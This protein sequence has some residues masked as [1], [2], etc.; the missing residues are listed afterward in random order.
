MRAHFDVIVIGGGPAGSTTATL[1]AKQGYRVLLLEKTKFPRYHIGE[2]M[3]TGILPLLGELGL[4]DEISRH[5]FIKKYGGTMVWGKDYEHWD[6]RFNE[7]DCFE[8]AY[9]VVRAEFDHLLLQNARR[10]G[11]TVLEETRVVETLFEKA[12]CIG[13][14]YVSAHS[15]TKDAAYASFIVDASGQTALL[16]RKMKYLEWRDDL[17]NIAIWAYYQGGQT[18]EGKKAGDI[19]VE[20]VSKGWLWVIPLHDNTQSVGWVVPASE[21]NGRKNL[22]EVY[23]QMIAHS[24]V[25]KQLLASAT[26]VSPFSTA[27]DWSYISKRFAG[28]GFLLVGDAAGFVDPLFSTGVFLAMKSASLA[29]KTIQYALQGDGQESALLAQYERLYRGSLDTIFSFICFFYDANKEKEIYWKEAQQLIDPYQE[30]LPRENF[31]QLV[32]GHKIGEQ[33]I[34][35]PLQMLAHLD[36]ATKYAN[37]LL[38]AQSLGIPTSPNQTILDKQARQE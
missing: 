25:A 17:K 18:Q 4:T 33:R 7:E 28:P 6:F 23:D 8:H 2:S 36:P 35:S 15:A 14:N 29:A 22:E 16:S 20:H 10:C 30:K 12:R 34:F 21:A 37:D 19:V 26:R 24:S 13:V 3:I 5:G 11:V 38:E 31:I 27:R 32:S 9:Q 1:L